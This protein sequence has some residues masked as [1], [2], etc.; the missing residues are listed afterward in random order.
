MDSDKQKNMK[1]DLRDGFTHECVAK[2]YGVD[3]KW[4]SVWWKTHTDTCKIN[5]RIGRLSICPSYTNTND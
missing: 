4:L 3:L 5:T 2:K 1:N